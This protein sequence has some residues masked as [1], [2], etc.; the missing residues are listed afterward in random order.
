MMKLPSLARLATK[1]STH[2][3]TEAKKWMKKN[4]RRLADDILNLQ[5]DDL[6]GLYSFLHGLPLTKLMLLTPHCPQILLV[7]SPSVIAKVPPATFGSLLLQLPTEARAKLSPSVF[8]ELPPSHFQDLR[9]GILVHLPAAVLAQLDLSRLAMLPPARLADV[10]ALPPALLERHS[11]ETLSWLRYL[12]DRWDPAALLQT[13][14]TPQLDQAPAETP[15]STVS[16]VSLLEDV[17]PAAPAQTPAPANLNTNDPHLVDSTNDAPLELLKRER[18]ALQKEV[19]RLDAKRRSVSEDIQKVLEAS[20]WDDW[21]PDGDPFEQMLE[22]ALNFA[23]LMK[24]HLEAEPTSTEQCREETSYRLTLEKAVQD[25]T[26][27]LGEQTQQQ[28]SIQSQNEYE[29]EIQRLQQIIDRQDKK[30]QGLMQSQ[31][32]RHAATVRRLIDEHTAEI[33]DQMTVYEKELAELRGGAREQKRG[34]D[35][36]MK[37]GWDL[38][39]SVVL[40]PVKSMVDK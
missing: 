19:A 13:A 35:P 1:R 36:G 27:K 3:A 18:D 30:Y 11:A 12:A 28:H 6:G 40:Y 34:Q 29:A 26:A 2:P 22:L 9:V 5:L 39:T 7:L 4:G 33:S 37:G 16:P 38:S 25:L 24:E 23:R 32:E 8:A 14:S 10:L 21:D 17:P 20:G 31:E 15:D